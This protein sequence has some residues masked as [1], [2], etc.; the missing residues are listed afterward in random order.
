[1]FLNQNDN[2]LKELQIWM[3][4]VEVIWILYSVTI[5]YLLLFVS[6]RGVAQDGNHAGVGHICFDGDGGI[7]NWIVVFI[8]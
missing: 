5:S 2:K 4:P 8:K 3:H 1:M 6:F 7:I